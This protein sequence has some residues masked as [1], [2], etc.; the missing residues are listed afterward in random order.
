M[1]RPCCSDNALHLAASFSHVRRDSSGDRACAL[2]DEVLCRVGTPAQRSVMLK[3]K[4]VYVMEIMDGWAPWVGCC[5]PAAGCNIGLV[6]MENQGGGGDARGAAVCIRLTD[7]Y[8]HQSCRREVARA[9][10]ELGNIAQF[11]ATCFLLL[12]EFRSKH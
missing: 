6:V 9:A 7:R 11:S 4:R 10:N 1:K 5:W 12:R 3:P 2:N 8:R